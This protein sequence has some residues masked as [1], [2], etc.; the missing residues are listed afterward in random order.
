MEWYLWL[1]IIIV[2][3]IVII[4]IL[5]KRNEN[6]DEDS[7]LGRAIG[8]ISSGCSKIIKKIVRHDC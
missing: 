4:L 3:L 7:F 2:V 5:R 8:N 1:G 6:S